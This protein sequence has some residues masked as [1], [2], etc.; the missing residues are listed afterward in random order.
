M[1]TLARKICDAV[2]RICI[3]YYNF[4]AEDTIDKA[5]ALRDDIEKL[6][7][8]L[9]E[10]LG[11]DGESQELRSYVVQV[12]NDYVEAAA[13]RDEVLMLDTLDYGLRE[14]FM[15]YIDEEEGTESYEQ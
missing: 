2:N 5:I 14:I 9:F 8:G 4:K 7:G 6:A 3:E 12:L 15:L 13:Q 1:E 10:M 11:N